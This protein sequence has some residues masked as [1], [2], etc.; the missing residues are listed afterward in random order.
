MN[1]LDAS[2]LEV[3]VVVEGVA[4]VCFGKMVVVD[5][6]VIVMVT[7][8]KLLGSI[9][10]AVVVAIAVVGVTKLMLL[11]LISSLNCA[12]VIT[13]NKA[14]MMNKMMLFFI[15]T[16]FFGCKMKKEMIESLVLVYILYAIKAA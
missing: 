14:L 15:L 7:A 1:N 13:K 2:L 6:S 10:T 9:S 8:G 3:V 12:V 11:V 5:I 4:T 16:V